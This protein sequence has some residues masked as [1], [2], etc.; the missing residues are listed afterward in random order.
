MQTAWVSQV[1]LFRLEGSGISTR[2]PTFPEHSQADVPSAESWL[3]MTMSR[4]GA[5]SFPKRSTMQR[6]FR[7]EGTANC[8]HHASPH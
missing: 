4:S 1:C 6:Q 5:G 8:S 7:R 3:M 2:G